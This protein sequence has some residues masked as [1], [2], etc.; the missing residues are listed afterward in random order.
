MQIKN[1]NTLIEES[2]SSGQITEELIERLEDITRQYLDRPSFKRLPYTH[3]LR[4]A[5][6]NDLKQ[7]ILSFTGNI[8][9]QCV[10]VIRVACFRET[11]RS[12][13]R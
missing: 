6:L 7:S 10:H 13:L 1:L 8:F 3:R 12:K 2:K 9:P 11:M 5:A 4:D